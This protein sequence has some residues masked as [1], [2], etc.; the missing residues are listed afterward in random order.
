MDSIAEV[1]G[2]AP[3]SPRLDHG[4]QPIREWDETRTPTLGR[5]PLDHRTRATRLRDRPLHN[6]SRIRQADHVPD[7][8]ATQLAKANAGQC[9]HQRDIAV[10]PCN[11][12]LGRH[13]VEQD[14]EW[15]D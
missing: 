12:L 7:T 10:P 14:L 3:L 1:V 11:F 8:K 4:P 15:K 13:D 6:Q 9:E 2:L 5:R